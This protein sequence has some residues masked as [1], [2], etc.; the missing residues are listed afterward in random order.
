MQ[1]AGKLEMGEEYGQD[2]VASVSL[3]V[4]R[5]IVLHG[6]SHFLRDIYTVRGPISFMRQ[7][8]A[9]EELLAEIIE[10]AVVLESDTRGPSLLG[11]LLQGLSYLIKQAACS[12]WKPVHIYRAYAKTKNGLPGLPALTHAV[13]QG[14]DLRVQPWQARVAGDAQEKACIEREFRI[15]VGG[16]DVG[17]YRVMKTGSWLGAMFLGQP[18]Q[19]VRV[20]WADL[21]GD[22]YR[23]YSA[24]GSLMQD[25]LRILNELNTIG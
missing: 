23:N 16:R 1:V 14:A 11:F 19:I 6:F 8:L 10:N 15:L 2:L 22:G 21:F 9:D 13:L 24:H 3:D 5:E 18:G 17:V 20:A 25:C 12:I 7:A 4:G